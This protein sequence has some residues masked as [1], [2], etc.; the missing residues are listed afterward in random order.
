MA[1]KLAYACADDDR[2]KDAG[3]YTLNEWFAWVEKHWG[4]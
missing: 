2:P 3:A 1:P 4:D